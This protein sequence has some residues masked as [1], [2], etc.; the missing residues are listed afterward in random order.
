[1]GAKTGISWCHHTFNI[2]WGC[3]EV[4][5]E[6]AR[7]YARKFAER[8]GHSADGTK[9]ALWG[10]NSTRRTFG[11]KYWAQLRQWNLIAAANS[12]QEL[13]FITSMG[14][15][16]EDHPIN[17]EQRRRLWGEIEATPWLIH[18]LLTK[19]PE[20]FARFLPWGINDK[21][22]RNVWLGTTIG[23]ES[24][25][26]RLRP[27]VQMPAVRRFI[28]YEP[29]LERVDWGRHFALSGGARSI[30]WLIAGAESGPGFRRAEVD[31]FREARDVCADWRIAYHFK[32]H[33]GLRPTDG[34]DLLDGE[35]IKQVPTSDRPIAPLPLAHAVSLN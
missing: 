31:W 20:N 30:H 25:A 28:S 6:C 26:H 10:A 21:P 22:W 23:L 33:G 13:V 18:L 16:F 17:A 35:R 3:Q 9:P 15:T 24:S 11:D 32:Q 34:G 5:P 4:S 7:C 29:A 14:D 19:R 27:L 8:V 1:M 2:V 12:A